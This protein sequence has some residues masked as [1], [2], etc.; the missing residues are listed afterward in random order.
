MSRFLA[1]HPEAWIATELWPVGLA[2]S[3]SSTAAYLSQLQALGRM[4][5]RVD[6]RRRQL[7]MLDL[8]W[9]ATHVTVEKGN[10]TNLLL[11]RRDWVL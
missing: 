2:R 1:A 10:H 9:L 4:I 8:D 5:L 3:G 11:P 7:T 6:E